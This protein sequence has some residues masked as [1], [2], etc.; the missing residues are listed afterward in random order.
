LEQG[1]RLAKA[2]PDR[3]GVM[4]DFSTNL[5]LQALFEKTY[6]TRQKKRKK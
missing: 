5:W 6:E 2:G 4:V 3:L 1:C